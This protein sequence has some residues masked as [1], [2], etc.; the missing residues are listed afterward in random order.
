[1]RGSGELVFQKHKL[2]LSVDATD[3]AAADGGDSGNVRTVKDFRFPV[4]TQW[5]EGRRVLASV[6]GKDGIEIATPP[7]FKGTDVGVWSPEDFL[8][9]AAASC[10]VVTLLAVAERRGIPVRDVAVDAVGRMGPATTAGS[11]SSGST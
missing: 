7:E 11:A 5:I 9:A 3:A 10:F 6:D 8:V 1:L 2:C 4:S